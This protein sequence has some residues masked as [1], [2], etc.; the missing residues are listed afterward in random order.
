MDFGRIT[1]Y[2]TK[3]W[4]KGTF[5]VFRGEQNKSLFSMR[6]KRQKKNI[7]I[8]DGRKR[9]EN[10]GELFWLGNFSRVNLFEE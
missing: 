7:F 9:M 1:Q 8:F 10:L 5:F 4:I 3:E 6:E 2:I